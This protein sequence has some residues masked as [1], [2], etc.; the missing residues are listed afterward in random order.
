[1]SHVDKG[2]LHAYLD[3]A[4]DEYPASEARRVR[5]HLESCAVCVGRL[6]EERRLRQD[7]TAMLGLAAPE[8]EVPSFEELKAYVKAMRPRPTRASLRLY[9]MGWAASVVLALGAGWMVRGGQLT[10]RDAGRPG[11]AGPDASAASRLVPTAEREVGDFATSVDG[12]EGRA[13]SRQV[14]RQEVVIQADLVR[15]NLSKTAAQPAEVVVGGVAELGVT[16]LDAVE[17]G[18][19]AQNRV[20]DDFADRDE[21]EARR[22]EAVALEEAVVL[23]DANVADRASVGERVNEAELRSVGVGAAVA[24]LPLAQARERADTVSID[25][26]VQPLVAAQPEQER[27]AAPARRR[28]D[29]LERT[30]SRIEAG[31]TVPAAPAD[32]RTFDEDPAEG[33][34]K[35]PLLVPG[36]ELIGYANVAEGTTPSGVHVVQTLEDGGILDVYHLPEGVAPSVLPPLGDGRNEVRA[37]RDGGWVILR[38][39]LSTGALRELLARLGPA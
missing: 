8:V 30:T 38:A 31:A 35:G 2:A 24:T 12:V 25:R 9:R 32:Q 14:D 10:Q 15:D 28:A 20:V 7:A 22:E 13:V 4:L 39:A 17:R 34:A 19:V 1:M 27:V 26:A 3:S 11:V 29:G 6:E 33:A 21:I 23:A 37:E 36:L 16:E 5:E 18:V